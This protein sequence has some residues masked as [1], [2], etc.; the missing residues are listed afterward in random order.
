MDDI[1]IL[2]SN[3]ILLRNYLVYIKQELSK[4]KLKLK[5]NYQ[6]FPVEKRRIDFIGYVFNHT[7][8]VLRKRTKLNF[9]RVCNDIIKTIKYESRVTPH[10]IM[11][12][13][14][15]NGIMVWVS[16]DR[17]SNM[18]CGRVERAIYFGVDAI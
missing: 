14:S 7:T 5:G 17:L 2:A 11:S 10:M 12:L 18:Y 6:Y 13:S 15:Y 3:K 9:I 4:Y 1:I 16:S 8:V